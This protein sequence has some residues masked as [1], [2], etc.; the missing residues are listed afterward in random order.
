MTLINNDNLITNLTANVVLGIG[1]HPDDLDFTAAG[2]IAKLSAAG[3]KAY[4]LVLTDGGKGSEDENLTSAELTIVRQRE[5]RQAAQKLG[6]TEVFFLDYED[7]A[8]VVSQRLKRDLVRYIRQLKPEIVFTIDP[9]LVYFAPTN[10]INHPDHRA[11][12]QA[13]LDAVFPLARDRLSFPELLNEGL[14]PHKVKT[15]LLTN[16]EKQ[17]YFVDITGTIDKKMAAIASHASQA[18]DI[19]DA[20]RKYR[21]QARV[22]GMT[23]GADYAEGFVRIDTMV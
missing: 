2:T 21:E 19:A 18:K 11:C 20:D 17:Q 9:T 15:V 3:A 22:L 6:V 12:G 23:I 10:M 14:E 1:A 5:Q 7:G 8:L 13:V 4:Y 16:L